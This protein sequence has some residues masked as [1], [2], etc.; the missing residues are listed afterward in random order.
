MRPAGLAQVERAR[1]DGRRDAALARAR[2][3]EKFVEMLAH[4][5]TVYPQRC[6]IDS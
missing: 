5:E 4:G 1:A 2:Q 3:I 6:R